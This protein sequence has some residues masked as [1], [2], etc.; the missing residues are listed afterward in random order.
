M[1]L[2]LVYVSY[3]DPLSFVD[4]ILISAVI[5]EQELQLTLQSMQTTMEKQHE[6]Y[7]SIH[8]GAIFDN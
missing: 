2:Y 3:C 7:I 1:T 4:D 5:C 6:K 8:I